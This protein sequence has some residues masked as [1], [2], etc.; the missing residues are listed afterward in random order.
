MSPWTTLG[1]SI[2]AL[3]QQFQPGQ[4]NY[5]AKLGYLDNAVR[6]ELQRADPAAV[7]RVNGTA[8][9]AGTS[10][11]IAL[12]EGQNAID[13]AVENVQTSCGFGV[14]FFEFSN[15]RTLLRDWAAKKGP[16][17]VAEYRAE[18]NRASI[19]GLPTGL[20]ASAS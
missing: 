5:T 18:K 15:D 10:Q 8:V 13:V 16:E 7:V 19:D 2:G 9:A 17:G 20:G 1:L 14:P 6:V 4:T 3:D 11:R 12:S